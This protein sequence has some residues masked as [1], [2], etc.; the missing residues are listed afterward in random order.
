M[1]PN[2]LNIIIVI[3]TPSSLKFKSDW[4]EFSC[5][6]SDQFEPDWSTRQTGIKL[7]IKL[8]VL[9]VDTYKINCA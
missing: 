5:N 4:S 7:D 1:F 6:I 8:E 9:L 3:I 2:T